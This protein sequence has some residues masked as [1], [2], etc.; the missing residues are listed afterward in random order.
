MN[1][2]EGVGLI[3]LM[4]S[5]TIG[6]FVL[7]GVMQLYLTS[8]QNVS[9]FEGSSRIQENARYTFARLEKDIG[10]AGNLG[11]FSFSTMN[12]LQVATVDDVTTKTMSNQR[13]ANHLTANTGSGQLYDFTRFI[14][15]EN[16]EGPGAVATDK[17]I[18]RFASTEDRYP[19]EGKASGQLALSANANGKFSSGDTAIIAD[20]STVSVFSVSNVSG[21]NIQYAS[22]DFDQF[23]AEAAAEVTAEGISRAYVYGGDSV[24]VAYFVGT[25]AAGSAASGTCSDATP[26]YCA[27]F[28]ET[29]AGNPIEIVE[30]VQDL[31]FEFGRVDDDGNL[32]LKTSDGI[33]DEVDSDDN[34]DAEYAWAQIDRVKVTATFNSINNA[35]TNEGMD[36]LTRTYS[37]VFVIHNQLP[38]CSDCKG[39]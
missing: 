25:S 15:G 12:Q 2:Q 4:V 23:Q 7:A 33:D 37:Q 11:C 13:L 26:Q 34:A 16:D 31:Q 32:V 10:Q 39:I 28:R 1:K 8:S 30:G 38:V 3:E 22:G 35:T 18:L 29:V 6:V 14:D 5:I 21:S 24:A 36:L 27:L 20:C 19:L 17:I 9:S